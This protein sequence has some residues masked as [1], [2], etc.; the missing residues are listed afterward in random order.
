MKPLL[1]VMQGNERLASGLADRLGAE[2][3]LPETRRF[4]D[5][6]TYLRLTADLK[7]RPVA[8]LCTLDRPDEKIPPLLFAADAARD[9]G[10][11]RIGL[12]APYLAYMRQDTRFKPG[13]AVTS[14]PFARLLSAA[15]DWLVTVDPHLHRY[16]SLDALYGIPSV[17]VHAAPA[18]ARWIGDNVANAL[19]IGPDVESEQWVAAVAREAGMPHAV[20]TK[21]RRGDRDVDIS[22][23][24]L[25]SRSDRVPVLVDDII[26]SG[27]TM[28]VAVQ[29]L[30]AQGWPA[31]VCIG[32]HGLFADES[33]IA[34][35][36]TGARVVTC[37]TVPHKTNSIDVCPLLAA[38]VSGFVRC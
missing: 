1:L 3:A 36:G 37:N 27:R 11:A 32:V 2:I 8:I 16:H 10:A 38:A 24:H 34:L 17:A 18:I 5:G 22:L 7:D 15:F 9:L 28:L 6:E 14:R 21:V 33:D 35:G 26:S 13:E 19:V 30:R 31:P 4:P 12:I 25:G 29:K 23:Q 20:L